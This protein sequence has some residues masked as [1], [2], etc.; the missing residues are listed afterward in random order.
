MSH[1]FL[2][3]PESQK[4]NPKKHP[5]DQ[6]KAMQSGLYGHFQGLADGIFYRAFNA[7][8]MHAGPSGKFDGKVVGQ[9]FAA[10]ALKKAI[11]HLVSYP[12]PNR[13]NGIKEFLKHVESADV[14]AKFYVH[15]Y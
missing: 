13:A 9:A 11:E 8:N 5:L 12:D 3:V 1:E 7:Q 6:L 10:E 2:I 14:S 4:P 15:F